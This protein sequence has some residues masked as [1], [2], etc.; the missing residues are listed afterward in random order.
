[1]LGEG[2]RGVRH[3]P[4]RVQHVVGQYGLIDVELEMALAAGD[5]DRGV[6]A[7]HL[8]AHHRHR[9]AL[10]RID[11][12]RHDR[13]ARLVLRQHQFAEARTR[14]RSEQAD[15]VGDLE[16]ACRDRI[17]GAVPRYIGVVRS[18]RLEFVGRAGERQLGNPGNVLC[19]QFC[20]AR[21]RIEAGADGGAAL[22]QGV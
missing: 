21:L 18:Q 15:V 10:R 6:I 9:L 20:K 3:Q 5:R 16:Q 22:R 2:A 11:L 12:A 13:G 19:E 14:T 4:D 7:E 17:D 8:A 1:M